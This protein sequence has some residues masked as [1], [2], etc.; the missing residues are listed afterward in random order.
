M[1]LSCPMMLPVSA[2][3]TPLVVVFAFVVE[4][5]DDLT[6]EDPPAFV[7]GAGGCAVV[8][9]AMLGVVACAGTDT[10]EDALESKVEASLVEPPV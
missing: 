2:V 1:M 7:M 6:V 10:A 9:C 5:G 8:G 4:I 3:C